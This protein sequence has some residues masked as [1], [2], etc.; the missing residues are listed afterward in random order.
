VT[1][2][3]I[4]IQIILVILLGLGRMHE[5]NLVRVSVDHETDVHARC[6]GEEAARLS[7]KAL[8]PHGGGKPRL[9]S[10]ARN[11]KLVPR[12]M[13]NCTIKDIYRPMRHAQK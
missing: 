7:D 1:A 3:E 6:T 9:A 8:Q 5:V 11:W 2:E 12:N 13:I 4:L 10:A